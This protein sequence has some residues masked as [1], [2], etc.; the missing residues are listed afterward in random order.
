MQLLGSMLT[1][2]REWASNSEALQTDPKKNL[3]NGGPYFRSL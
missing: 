3:Q 2:C 1:V